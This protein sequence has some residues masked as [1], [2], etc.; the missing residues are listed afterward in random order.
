M[1]EFN[2]IISANDVKLDDQGLKNIVAAIHWR[3]EAIDG[4]FSADTCGCAAVGEPTP[5]DFTDY[6]SLTKEQEVKWLEAT[7]NVSQLQSDLEA[8]IELLKNPIMATLAP[9]F[10][11]VQAT[12]VINTIVDAPVEEVK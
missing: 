7:I 6:Q 4:N 9:P 2:W 10:T 1:A 8:R 3:Y 5:A 11:S 12:E